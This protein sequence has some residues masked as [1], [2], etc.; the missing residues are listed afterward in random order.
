MA[1]PRV[2][3]IA[4]GSGRSPLWSRAPLLRSEN[5]AEYDAMQDALACDVKPSGPI[6]EMHVSDLAYLVWEIRR[7]RR[8]KAG[9]IRIEFIGAI[10][11]LVQELTGERART[12][13]DDVMPSEEAA[14]RFFG[15]AKKRHEVLELLSEFGLDE[16]SIEAEAI[17]HCLNVLATIEQMLGSLEARRDKA[18][19]SIAA[20]RAAFAQRLRESAKRLGDAE[21]NDHGLLEQPVHAASGVEHGKRTSNRR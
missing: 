14:L 21:Y 3:L 17:G 8:A 7:F 6:E 12:L 18:L 1:I 11:R 15:N 10:Q 13:F 2:R 9:I 16:S 19:A 20:H 5:A 4:T